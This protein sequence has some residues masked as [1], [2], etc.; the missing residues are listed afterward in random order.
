MAGNVVF[1]MIVVWKMLLLPV[2][3][4]YMSFM[5]DVLTI[6]LL[7]ATVSNILTHIKTLLNSN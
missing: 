6:I 2:R 1:V 3:E 4:R 7:F 5:S